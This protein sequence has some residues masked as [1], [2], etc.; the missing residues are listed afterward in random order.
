MS[1]AAAAAASAGAAAAL[2]T[3]TVPIHKNRRRL[4]PEINQPILWSKGGPRARV[5]RD[6]SYLKNIMLAKSHLFARP[7]GQRLIS[8]IH[9]LLP[10]AGRKSNYKKRTR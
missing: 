9:H 5:R 1:A 7:A 3:G 6:G 8:S 2:C 10:E 4:Y